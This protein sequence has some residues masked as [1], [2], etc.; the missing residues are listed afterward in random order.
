MSRIHGKVGAIELEWMSPLR[1][2]SGQ[3]QARLKDGRVISVSWNRDR[4][5][6][7]IET[8]NGVFGFDI[9]G[10]ATDEGG[11]AY[12][13]KRRIAGGEWS[14]LSFKRA[15]EESAAAA[16]GVQKRG[17]RVRAQMPG[18]II[19]VSVK[20]GDMVEKGQSLLVMEAMKMENEIRAAAS[21]KISAVKVTEGQAVETGADLC[22]IEPV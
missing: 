14:G 2:N 20:V 3:A 15:G 21:G 9:A 22:L 1:G 19:R 4:E 18:K 16:A 8:D 17:V 11:I 6:L 7:W 13:V 5:G 10:E 12:H